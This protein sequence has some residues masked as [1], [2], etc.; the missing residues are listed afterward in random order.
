MSKRT[1]Q[2]NTARAV[3][4]PVALMIRADDV[5]EAEGSFSGY[6]NV[7]DTV[8]SYS[9]KFAKGCF[10]Q[11]LKEHADEG[12][13]PKLLWQHRY[14]APVGVWD[15]MREDDKGLYVRGR[16]ADTTLARDALELLRLQSEA[17]GA[18]AIDGLSVGFYPRAWERDEV[19]DDIITFTRVE[20]IETSLVTFQSNKPSR[21]DQV[22]QALAAGEKVNPAHL[23]AYL[24]SEC[25][26]PNQLAKRLSQGLSAPDTGRDP[27]PD[28][29][30]VAECTASIERLTQQ[31]RG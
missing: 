11:S 26:L 27:E 29:R 19:D 4:M 15:E 12:T 1:Q 8:D 24:R 25:G 7:F 21:V 10:V 20:L 17:N 5:D 9:T 22:R 14:D 23:E 30:R 2:P 13:M 16:L 18:R 31:L 3:R 6:A 28:I